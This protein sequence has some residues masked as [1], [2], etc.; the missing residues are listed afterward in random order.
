MVAVATAVLG[1]GLQAKGLE[2]VFSLDKLREVDAT[3]ESAIA[4]GQC[5]GGV[6]WLERE[7]QAYVRAY[8]RR[9][10]EPEPEPMTEDTVFDVASLTKVIA[11]A[12]AVMVLVEH[13][14]LELDQPV[15]R[16]WPE[17]GREG[18]EQ[19]TLRHLLTHTSGL[20]AGFASRPEWSGAAAALAKICEE[21]PLAPA[22]SAFVYS[23]LNFIVLG[24]VVRRVSGQPLDEFCQQWLF[25]PLRMRQT[26]FR[27]GPELLARVAPTERLPSGEVLRGTVHDPT[28]RR[29]GGVAGHAGLFST[30]ED[31]A[32]F[33]RMLLRLGAVDGWPLLRPETVRLMTSVQTPALLPVRR[34]LGWDIDSPYSAPRGR[35]FPLGSYGH[36]GWTGCSLWIDP[37]SGTFVLFLSNRNH[38]TERGN[39]QELRYQL[40]TL[41]AEAVKGFPF[42]QGPGTLPARE[43]AIR[44]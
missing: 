34:G 7:G 32:H 25:R 8:G 15:A 21:K 5:P 22:G 35:W 40:G 14:L 36:T 43:A 29:M 12:P 9:A 27:P 41:A 4:A 1:L 30:A 38:P 28:A 23:D 33:A 37:S 16:Y 6:L 20:R 13:G 10:L 19:L 18:K 42:A 39:L 2:G 31:L 26:R 3:I 24:E 17:F 11:T 44:K